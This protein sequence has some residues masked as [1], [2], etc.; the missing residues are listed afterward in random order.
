[1]ATV[2]AKFGSTETDK[3]P[4]KALLRHPLTNL[5]KSNLPLPDWIRLLR[6]C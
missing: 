5:Y 2:D 3:L 6:G 4:V 1:M